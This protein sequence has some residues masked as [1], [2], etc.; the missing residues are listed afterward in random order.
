MLKVSV[1]NE[2]P[3]KRVLEVEGRLAGPWVTELNRCWES[4]KERTAAAAIVVRLANVSFVDETGSDLLRK[5]FQAGAQLEGNGCMVRALI[6]Q[7][8][9]S[10]FPAGDCEEERKKRVSVESGVGAKGE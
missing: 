2:E 10:R 9:G 8:T 4:E 5:M 1:K 3:G 6:G 7:I